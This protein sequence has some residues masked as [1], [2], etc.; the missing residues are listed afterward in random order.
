MILLILI[1][2]NKNY[3]INNKTHQNNNNNNKH[4]SKYS[5]NNNTK[6]SKSFI[7]LKNYK[8]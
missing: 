1:F 8:N 5:N 4:N 3:H 2:P 7:N 6:V